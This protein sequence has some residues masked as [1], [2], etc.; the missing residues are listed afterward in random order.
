MHNHSRGSFGAGLESISRI[1]SI[2]GQLKFKI[3]NLYHSIPSKKYIYF[4]GEAEYR[5]R[6]KNLNKSQKLE[7]F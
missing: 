7:E 3:K 2:W 6:I 1:E 5:L 4:L